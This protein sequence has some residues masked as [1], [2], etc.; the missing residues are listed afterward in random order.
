MLLEDKNVNTGGTSS[1]LPVG[2]CLASDLLP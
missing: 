1:T 2:P